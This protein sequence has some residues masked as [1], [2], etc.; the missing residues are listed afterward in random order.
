LKGRAAQAVNLVGYL[1]V[2]YKSNK[3][4]ITQQKRLFKKTPEFIAKFASS[5][6]PYSNSRV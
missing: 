6:I 2:Y 1:R 4:K 5:K 3:T